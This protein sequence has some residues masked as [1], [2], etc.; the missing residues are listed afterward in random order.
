VQRNL[1]NLINII[2]YSDNEPLE[3]CV[4][5]TRITIFPVT[6][7]SCAA[8]PIWFLIF[9]VF[10]GLYQIWAV[11]TRRLRYR[12]HA[13]MLSLSVPVALLLSMVMNSSYHSRMVPLFIIGLIGLWNVW[14][15]A[16]QIKK[17]GFQKH[18]RK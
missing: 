7:M 9:G 10:T 14:K 11:S 5:L 17:R 16:F 18:E 6:S 3:L 4:A 2:K 15:T 12:H 1:R 8:T 13:N